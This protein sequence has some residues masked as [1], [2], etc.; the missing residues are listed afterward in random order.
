MSHS[1]PKRR[2]QKLSTRFIAA[3]I[4]LE[5]FRSKK[6]VKPIFD[7]YIS[8]LDFSAK[9][10]GLIKELVYGV[11]RRRQDVDYA[12]Q[13]LSK[14]PLKKIDPFLHQVLRLG[15]YQILFL[16]R[17]PDFA[18]VNEAVCSCRMKRGVQVPK[19]LTGFVNG[20]LR[21][22]VRQKEEMC[23]NIVTADSGHLFLNH[24]EWMISRWQQRF[25]RNE[26][27]EICRINNQQPLLTLRVN[28][29]KIE[30]KRFCTQLD[31]AGIL[32]SPAR[33]APDAIHLATGTVIGEI[34]G[35]TEG[36]FQIQDQAAQL[37]TLLLAPFEHANLR[38]LDACAGLGGKTSYILQFLSKDSELHAVEPESFRAKKLR[39]IM[40][41]YSHCELHLH[42]KSLFELSSE[43]LSLFERVLVDAPCSGTGVIG[44]HPDIRWSRE[45]KDILCFSEKQLA[46]LTQAALFTAPGG[47]LVYATC[48]IEQEE[49]EEVVRAFLGN[50][51]QF[52]LSDPAPFLPQEAHELL[53]ENFFSPQPA[54][55]I[56]GFFAARMQRS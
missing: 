25:G 49:N 13:Q 42:Q 39:E 16:D 34:P 37:A 31:E 3:E 24:P 38:F 20:V 15:L 30:Y 6:P 35:Y 33:F 21:Q 5:L 7:F 54:E 55:D 12:L 17:I 47:V 4:L 9:D 19:R 11:L 32:W 52:T 28:R 40:K 22:A 41:P 1:S 51:P 14:T 50:H 43:Q 46:L 53:R 27:E 48:S 29:K 8:R 10:R 18:A 45:E 23:E 56:D 2:F 26:A 44:R 36:Y